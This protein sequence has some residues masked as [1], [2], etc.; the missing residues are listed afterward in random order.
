MF[1]RD[2]CNPNPFV[3]YDTYRDW[4]DDNPDDDI[5]A[6]DWGVD[7]DYIYDSITGK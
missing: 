3:S 2:D 4:L 6:D 5:V 1:P 7:P